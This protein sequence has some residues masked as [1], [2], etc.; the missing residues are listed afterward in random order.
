MRLD[1]HGI[2]RR[3]AREHRRVGVPG[4]ERGAGKAHGDAA[5]HQPVALAQPDRRRAEPSLPQRLGRH[6]RHRRVR[7]GERLDAAVERV[8]AAARVAHRAALPGRVHHGLRRL[9]HVAVQ[10][11]DD[12]HAHAEAGLRRCRRPRRHRRTRGGEQCVDVGA[13]IVDAQRL[14]RVRRDLAADAIHGAGL[15]EFEGPPELRAKGRAARL[16]RRRSTA[17]PIRRFG[18]QREIA[19]LATRRPAARNEA[20]CFSNN[21]QR[22]SA[23]FDFLAA[24]LAPATFSTACAGR[25][26]RRCTRSPPG[27]TSS[28]DNV[29]VRPRIWILRVCTVPT[30]AGLCEIVT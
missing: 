22:D 11:I 20:S 3:E 4:R 30:S 17:M 13:R 14:E 5:R 6:V 8:R 24:T 28:A 27:T 10:A 2:A 7:V 15:V 19:A 12:L 29:S 16:G 1:D 25:H 18:E 23:H 21:S 26:C 9:E